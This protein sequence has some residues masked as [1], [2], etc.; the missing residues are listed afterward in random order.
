MFEKPYKDTKFKEYNEIGGK[1]L[2][3]VIGA[4]FYYLFK[5]VYVVII[6]ISDKISRKRNKTN[7]V[8][9]EETKIINK[10]ENIQINNKQSV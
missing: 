6:F 7:E 9:K 3:F 1:Y 2:G 10:K 5:S 4:I 8:S